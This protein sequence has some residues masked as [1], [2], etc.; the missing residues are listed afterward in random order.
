[1]TNLHGTTDAL[2]LNLSGCEAVTISSPKMT[3][4]MPVCTLND[5]PLVPK[6]TQNVSDIDGMGPLSKQGAGDE[7]TKKAPS[8]L[9]L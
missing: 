1:M 9:H 7:A 5:Q 8:L 2:E 6:E 3:D 4:P